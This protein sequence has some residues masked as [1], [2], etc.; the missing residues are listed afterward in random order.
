MEQE[1]YTYSLNGGTPQVSNVFS[2]LVA[3]TY[4][5]TVYDSFGCSASIVITINNA[6]QI[7]AVDDSGSINGMTGGI[8]VSNVLSNDLL[9]GSLVNPADINLTFVSTTHPNISLVGSNVVVA[10]GTPAG[11]YYLVYQICEIANPTN[12]DPATVTIVVSASQIIANDDNASGINGSIGAINVVN[13]FTNDLLNGNPVN[14]VDVV[15]TL[16]TPDPSGNLTLNPDGSVNVAPNTPGGTYTLTY[17]I[18]EVLNPTNCDQAVVTIQVI[19]TSDVSIVKTQINPSNLPVGSISGLVPIV[20]SV[21]TAGTK[22]YYFLHVQ[23]NGPDN[24][25]NATIT[26]M[27]PSGITNAEYSLNF[28]NSWFAWGGTRFLLDFANGGVN[29][30]LI[31]GD[32]DPTATG[33]LINTGTVYSSTT[34]DPNITNNE[35][36]VVT[37]INQSANLNLNKQTLNSPIVIGGEIIYQINVV[38]L[39]PSAAN[40]VIIT[41]VIDPSIL[42]NV[43]YSLN[44]GVSW[45]SPW[46]GSINIGTL[47]NG[48]S[49]SLQIKGTIIDATPNPNVDPIPNTASVNSD[50]PDPDVSNNTE[51]IFTPLNVEADVSILKTGPATVVAGQQI[52]YSIIV[53]NNSN[54]FAALD[55]H[56]NDLIN[57]AILA[58]AEYSADG[59]TTWLPWASPYILGTLNPLETFTL[60]IRGT[61]L[62]S[63]T[64]NVINTA[65]VEL[66]TPDP[67]ITNNTST[68]VTTIERIADLEIIKIQIDPAIIP[69]DSAALFGNPYDLMISPLQITAGDSIYYVL[70][71]TNHGPSDAVDVN[72]VDI[73]PAGI[74][75]FVASR[76]QANFGPWSNSGNLGTIIAGGR[77]LILM[78]GKVNDDAFG[79]ITNTATISNIPGIT[80]PDITNNTSTVVTP[81]ISQSDLAVVKTVN[82]STPYV[83]ANVTFTIVVTNNGPTTATSSQL[84][85]ILPNGYT[86]VSHNASSGIYNP[87]SGLWTI[88]TINFPG[89]ASLTITATVNNPGVGVSYLNTATV[90]QFRSI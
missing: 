72:I 40:N 11:T 24:S 42:S 53:T 86:Y 27:L 8:A 37:T 31:R 66:D 43:Q 61:V 82:N 77:C 13:V 26:D 71:Y 83:G 48:S 69:I 81:I 29:N 58:N 7:I 68:V 74:G 38:N 33:T 57:S 88:G 63:V 30:V 85:D 56:I 52:Q 22:I 59:G 1:T 15:L 34:T 55:V 39:G 5:I 41:D 49:F 60:L 79:S 32:V 21:I 51:T 90:S 46:T 62:S 67:D 89:T 17:Q 64:S 65:N 19:N 44:N 35:S 9:N 12:C 75:S 54:T 18:C 10:P 14:P 47:A 70:V 36:T 84:I 87:I 25:L 20:P 50:T 28:G 6:L 16:V 78:K 73:L 23:N 76:C 4:T 3:G 2:G 45:L 80:D